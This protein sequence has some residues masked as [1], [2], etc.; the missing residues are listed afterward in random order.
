MERSF[1]GVFLKGSLPEGTVESLG[2]LDVDVQVVNAGEGFVVRAKVETTVRAR[3]SRCTE[4]V[5]V[6]LSVGFAEEFRREGCLAGEGEAAEWF[7]YEG[8]EI[9]LSEAVRQN[10]LV[11]LP[12]KVVCRDDCPGLCPVCGRHLDA[13]TCECEMPRDDRWEALTKLKG[14]TEGGENSGGSQEEDIQGSKG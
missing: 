11:S 14:R 8:D 7:T 9:D 10:I 13:G 4:P 12:M 6:P 1:R 3:C 5:E 2:P